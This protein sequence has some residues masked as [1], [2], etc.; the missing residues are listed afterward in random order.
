VPP[1]RVG[2]VSTGG[3]RAFCYIVKCSWFWCWPHQ[4][5]R[6]SSVI[7]VLLVGRAEV[8]ISVHYSC[9]NHVLLDPNLI[10]RGGVEEGLDSQH[11]R[12]R[13]RYSVEPECPVVLS[14]RWRSGRTMLAPPNLFKTA[15]C[16]LRREH[17]L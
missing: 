7:R 4:K 3:H 15:A 14:V 1:L 17:T 9:L 8:Y 11:F 10:P 13:D 2:R 12:P 6:A 5:A 16:G